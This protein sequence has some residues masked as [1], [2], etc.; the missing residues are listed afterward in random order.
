[1][2]DN[3]HDNGWCDNDDNDKSC[4]GNGKNTDIE[5]CNII[6]NEVQRHY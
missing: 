3:E 2:K 6:C 1:M 4:N 5:R